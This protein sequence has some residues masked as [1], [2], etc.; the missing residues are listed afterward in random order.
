[1]RDHQ[2]IHTNIS[3]TISERRRR[4]HHMTRKRRGGR[5]SP[6]CGGTILISYTNST[7]WL[8]RLM[9]NSEFSLDWSLYSLSDSSNKSIYFSFFSC[10][11]LTVHT[12]LKVTLTAQL[13]DVVT[14]SRLMEVDTKNFTLMENKI[15]SV[16]VGPII[17]L[18]L[19]GH[20]MKEPRVGPYLLR[21]GWLKSHW[22]FPLVF[23]VSW[24]VIGTY[25]WKIFNLSNF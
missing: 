14:L 5:A 25:L 6:G 8:H 16:K 15:E 18:V 7:S 4:R 20:D 1:M 19:S 23:D 2:R 3:G 11:C 10:L 22:T 12:V 13:H 17:S 21:D 24:G 9:K